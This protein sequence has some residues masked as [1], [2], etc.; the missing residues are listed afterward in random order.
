[1]KELKEATSRESR[2]KEAKGGVF[3]YEPL[4]TVDTEI[5]GLHYFDQYD[6]TEIN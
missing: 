6:K 2:T 5:I 4:C 3:Y 1:M